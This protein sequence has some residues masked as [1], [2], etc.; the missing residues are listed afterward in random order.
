M[1]PTPTCI[2]RRLLQPDPDTRIQA[3]GD[4][5]EA[6][7]QAL[8]AL[9]GWRE[10]P[11]SQVAASSTAPVS[12]FWRALGNALTLHRSALADLLDRADPMPVLEQGEGRRKG[13]AGRPMP[14]RSRTGCC[15]S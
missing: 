15:V 10:Q 8:E 11:W 6:F 4:A 7:A 13:Q 5:V 1:L 14:T 12:G 3:Y 9:P 2:T